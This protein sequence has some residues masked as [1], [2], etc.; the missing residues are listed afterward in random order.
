MAPPRTFWATA[1]TVA[2]RRKITTAGPPVRSRRTLA[3]KPIE[4]KKAIISGVCSA[5]S[6]CS[7][8]TPEPRATVT[9]VATNSPPITGAGML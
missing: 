4:V 9:A 8:V 3:P 2:A 1:T 5:V 6:S 7:S